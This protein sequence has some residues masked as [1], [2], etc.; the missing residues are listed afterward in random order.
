MR[1]RDGFKKGCLELI[2][3]QVLSVKDCYG[4]EL[5][6]LIIE[7]S[8]GTVNFPEGSLYPCLYKLEQMKMISSDKRLVGKRRERVY[9]HIEDVGRKALDEMKTAYKDISSGIEQI[10]Q[11]A[12]SEDSMK[13]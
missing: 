10:L 9:Y 12:A 7:K 2:I 13:G 11:W 1:Y 6:Q 8:N 3:L 5:G 4:Y